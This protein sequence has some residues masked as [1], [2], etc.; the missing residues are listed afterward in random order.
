VRFRGT[1]PSLAAVVADGAD[2]DQN[3]S[4]RIR[5]PGSREVID[6]VVQTDFDPRILRIILPQQVPPGAYNGTLVGGKKDRPARLEID[7]APQL[8]VV[9]EQLRI[10]AHPGE[11][12]GVDLTLLNQGNVAVALRRIHAIGIFLNGGIERAL[13]RAYVQTLPKGTRRVDVIADSL[14]DAHGGLLRM[15]IE[16]GEGDVAAGAIREL[17][18]VFQLPS[19][20]DRGSTYEGNWELP[21]LVY[22]IVVEVGGEYKGDGNGENGGKDGTKAKP[23]ARKRPP[24]E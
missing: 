3:L 23:S 9:P 13:R 18:V 21:G 7:A 11:L 17:R 2:P 8:H 14:A 24:R 19:D 15:K 12:V 10:S 4:V 5:L 6:L 22:P 1:P 16:A 20:L